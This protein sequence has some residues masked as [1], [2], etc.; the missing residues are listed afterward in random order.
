MNRIYQ[1]KVE[2]V[3]V[4]DGQD[5]SGNAN[6]KKLDEWQTSIWCH[7]E[8]FQD[9]INYYILALAS[10]ADPEYATSRLIKDLR[11]R[12]SAAWETFPRTAEKDARN[13][14]DSLANW[15]GLS[16]DASIEDA[17]QAVLEGN[18]ATPQVHTLALGLLLDRCGGESAIQQGGRGYLPRFCDA[19]AKPTYDFSA[20]SQAA[21][22]GKDRL[23]QFL[24][25]E[26]RES[27]LTKIAGEMDLS[28]TVKLQPGEF[29]TPLDS[30]ARLAEAIQHVRSLLRDA[31]AVRLKEIAIQF[32]DFEQQLD[33]F[34]ASLDN[35][36]RE[37]VI[38]RN[39]KASK[40]LTF[41]T[42]AFKFFPC[43]LT[44][45]ILSLF[46]KKPKVTVAE[47]PE[48][49]VDFAI[50]GDDPI[51]LARGSR[52]F[53]F[54]AFTALPAWN[55]KSPGEPIWKEFDIA[56]FKEALKSLNQFHQKTQDRIGDE[57]NLRGQLA[58]MLGS[59]INGW[60]P[61]KTD[62]G[63]EEPAPTPLD[64]KLFQFT[65]ELERDLTQDLADTVVG[66]NKSAQ[67]GEAVYEYREGEWQLSTASLRGYS[68]ISEEWNSL[69]N[70]RA[71]TLT[72]A[73][74]EEVVRKHQRDEK[75]KKSLGSVPLFF[76]LCEKKYW[77]L[78]L[79]DEMNPEEAPAEKAFLK[80]M[81]SF[82]TTFRDF[83]RSLEPINLTPAEPTYS[84]RLYM[85][86]DLTDKTAKVAFGKADEGFTVECAIA[87]RAGNNDVKEQRVRLIYSA[88]R[89][90]RDELQ[91]GIESRWLQPMTRALGLK[92][93]ESNQP[94]FESA[95]SLMPDFV[96][97]S[98]NDPKT[99][100]VR[101]LLNFPVTLD[102]AWIHSGLGKAAMW[103]G[104]FNGTREKNL[105]LHWP[106]TISNKAN[107]VPWWKNQEII[108]RGFT[109]ASYDLGQKTAA[110]WALLRATCWDP[111]EREKGTKRP[112]R[113]VGFDGERMWF[114]E[115]VSTGV[116][117]LPGEDQRVLAIAGKREVEHF[118]KAGRNALESEW[119]DGMKLA[120]A[121]LAENP[122]N[123]LGM[124]SEE[125]SFPEQNDALIAL[126]N[127]RLSRLNT[128]HR[129]S[130]F[131]PDRPEVAPRRMR[132]IE[133]LNDELE[134]WKDADVQFW[135]KSVEAEDFKSFRSAAGTAFS[136]LRSKFGE[137]LIALANRV[138][139][140][141]DRSWQWD[142]KKQ[143]AGQ[144]LYGEL[145]DSGKQLGDKLAWIRGQ[146]GLSLAR[147][148]QL[149]NLRRLFLR[150]NRSFDRE[151]GMPAKFGRDD[152]GRRSGEPCRLLLD[153]IDRMKEQRINQT[154]HLILAEAI[155]V[156]LREHQIDEQ[157][158]EA[159]DIHGE[160][161]KIP[162]RA[163][164]DFIVIENLDRYL[165]SQGRS[166]SENSRLMKWA[167][168]AVRDKIKMLAEE[169]FGIPVV[170]AP[171]AYSSRFCA[172]TGVA[173]ARCIERSVLDSYTKESFAKWAERPQKPGQSDP[174]IFAVLL[175]QFEHLEKLN[176][177]LKANR[178]G[179]REK[180]RSLYTLFLP[181]QGGPLFLSLQEKPRPKSRVPRQADINAAINIGLRSVAA[182]TALDILHKIRAEK[183]GDSFKP[184]VKNAR[185]KSAFDSKTV[186][187]L[188]GKASNKLASAR[189]PNFFFDAKGFDCFD[190][191]KIKLADRDV[192][193]VSGVGLWSTVNKI[194]PGH[195]A[196]IN[197][198]RLSSWQKLAAD[199][200]DVPM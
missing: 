4:L 146:R 96:W 77:T 3:E 89:L 62:T 40:D 165:T 198:Q 185:E 154:A 163:S 160:Y 188:D 129:W 186:I 176:Q 10:L 2:V 90:L 71:D 66:E 36:S 121:L 195:L 102:T 190:L 1:G 119:Q 86:S 22:L 149:E 31:S 91:G 30:S 145:V 162:G 67:F 5:E 69:Y 150:Y 182:P 144:G 50:C 59:G 101:F 184:V 82:H 177:K 38:P 55:S 133:K 164:V 127:R 191:A 113:E 108:E 44:G 115:V 80:S 94:P 170:E 172:V 104:Q 51:K 17:F 81:V 63:E 114:A 70:S 28:W 151:A 137:Q 42:L 43:P 147:I 73:D 166:P 161:E 106:G 174:K 112:V 15:M 148:E 197:K 136:S 11:V 58:I 107:V 189:S 39:R 142:P 117:R 181:K 48:N 159:K 169:P 178:S 93:P 131:N 139:P 135:R 75:N 110:A 85:F 18:E 46:V 12:V 122:E 152:S 47:K 52:G 79:A 126:A 128:F 68:D 98:K 7:H 49:A 6:W 20:A 194:F 24:H 45:K 65:R 175:E 13:M 123:W 95:V 19:K 120:G 183:D 88:K 140:L 33:S 26:L 109:L 168:R 34:E 171:A 125:K 74:L 97:S 29:F 116:L 83:E 118:G 78:W 23:S 141:R 99:K 27:E 200:D 193:L 53:V 158:R 76:K 192:S 156:R 32:P 199:K 57:N 41:A 130:C 111:R 196:E 103:K 143:N 37:I 35:G 21:G 72:S 56:A 100:K 179:G 124:S 187:F 167:H 8:I 60:K 157:E 153:K 134:H 16:K 64:S 9:A 105:H 25:R 87:I 132:L 180:S 173:G 14:R 84:R 155:G 138:A 92:M 54:R 61:R